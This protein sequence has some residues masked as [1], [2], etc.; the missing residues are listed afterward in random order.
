MIKI[1]GI[2][3]ALSPRF[4]RNF[5]R[6]IINLGEL[7]AQGFFRPRRDANA[8]FSMHIT[9]AGG[10]NGTFASSALPITD[11]EVII[12]SDDVTATGTESRK[13][14]YH[15]VKTVKQFGPSSICLPAVLETK[16]A[17]STMCSGATLP[18]ITLESLP[19]YKHWITPPRN[20]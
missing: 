12:K 11:R 14:N 2:G 9:T 7:R 20:H 18:V 3:H 16:T 5:P 17:F 1:L 8:S 6:G 4:P 19:H 10:Q 13:L 15:I